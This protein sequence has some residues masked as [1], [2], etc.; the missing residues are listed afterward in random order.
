MPTYTPSG[1]EH[2]TQGI[3]RA[4]EEI[5]TLLHSSTLQC[6]AFTGERLQGRKGQGLTSELEDKSL[7]REWSLED[8]ASNLWER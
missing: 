2:G 4:G 5:S 7:P 6:L 1:R 3:R 8:Q